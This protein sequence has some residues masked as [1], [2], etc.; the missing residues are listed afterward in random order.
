MRAGRFRVALK[1]QHHPDPAVLERLA[2]GELPPGER[3]RVE[4]HLESCPECQWLADELAT[5]EEVLDRLLDPFDPAEYDLAF[6]RVLNKARGW[7]P[8]IVREVDDSASLFAELLREAAPRARWELV[9]EEERFYS[10]K[11]CQL[12]TDHSRESW[13]TAPAAALDFAGL[14]VGIARF[15]D[16]SRY[17]RGLV[18]DA[19]ARAWAYLG[20]AYRILAD[21]ARAERALWQACRHLELSGDPLTRGEVLGMMGSLSNFRDQHEEALHFY[22]QAIVIYREIEDPRSEARLLIA[23]GVALEDSCRHEEALRILDLALSKIRREDEPILWL[24]V[25]HNLIRTMNNMGRHE[26]AWK[27]LKKTDQAYLETGG[28]ILLRGRWGKAMVASHLGKL[29]EADRLLLSVRESFA[30]LGVA[31]EVAL[32]SLDLALVYARQR[33]R[34]ECRRTVAEVIPL[35]DSLGLRDDAFAARLLYEKAGPG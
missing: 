4:R 8:V 34:A 11:I 2:L 24:G 28:S 19:R 10:L 29:D 26:A 1:R 3:L 23:K 22:D 13:F 16:A 33:R 21:Y 25:Q 7:L 12:L 14:A 5:E 9:L 32:I 35:F 20:N 15:L 31:A 27:A 30:E 6:D 18:E 17:G